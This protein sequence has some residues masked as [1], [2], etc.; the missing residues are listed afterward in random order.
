MTRIYKLVSRTEWEATQASGQF[1]GSAADRADGYIHFST[2]S[3]AQETARR[4]FTGV[5]ELLLVTVDDQALGAAL[6]WER[7][8]GGE[9]FP[10]FYG[11]LERRLV[12]DQRAVPLAGDG[13]P[14]LGALPT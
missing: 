2:A 13:V 4:H 12:V 6:R 10:H 5:A 1:A 14:L 11:P 7:S 8:R 9:L 3:Q